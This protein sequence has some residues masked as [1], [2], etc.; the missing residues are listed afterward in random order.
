MS[1]FGKHSTHIARAIDR[2]KYG[3]YQ[4]GVEYFNQSTFT[5]A[6]YANDTMSRLTQILQNENGHLAIFEAAIPPGAVS[7]F[8]CVTARN[9]S[10]KPE[11]N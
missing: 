10:A 1:A 2:Q 7:L 11:N 3:S 4:Q 6:G 8:I 9:L 5:E